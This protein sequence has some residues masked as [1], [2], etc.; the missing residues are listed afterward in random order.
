MSYTGKCA[1][2]A[3]TLQIDA[4]P[5]ATRQCWCRQCQA[6]AAGGPTTNAIFPADAVAIEG[7]LGT[8]SWNADSGNTLTFHFCAACGSQVYG[9][10]SAR[11]TMKTVRFGVIDQPHDLAPS[12][13][14]WTEDAPP[15]AVFDPTLE[16]FARQPP[17]PPTPAA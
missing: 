16:L 10:S 5:L 1:C 2:G 11:P 3:V 9:Q 17:A 7:T 6:I 14:I 4:K 8:S 13:V 12:A 15:W